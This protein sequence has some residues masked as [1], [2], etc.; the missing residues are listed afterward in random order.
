MKLGTKIILT[1]TS[2]V[3]VGLIAFGISSYVSVDKNVKHQVEDS[4]N[5][6]LKSIVA[7]FEAAKNNSM[8]KVK[9]NMQ[10]ASEHI[11]EEGSLVFSD[12]TM[13]ID[14]LNTKTQEKKT[15][16]VKEIYL[17]GK[18]LFENNE[19]ADNLSKM[20][21]AHVTIFQKV[22]GGYL[23]ISTTVK[24]NEGQRVIGTYI[25]DDS[26]V[27]QAIERG[28]TFYGR[29]LVV[30]EYFT[31]AYEPIKIDGKIEGILSLGVKEKD[32]TSLEKTILDI[33]IGDTG[34]VMAVDN[35]GIIL[36]HPNAK[37]KDDS[38]H[39][40]T[41]SL[42]ENKKGTFYYEYEGRKKIGVGTYFEPFDWY[43]LATGFTDEF[44][45]DIRKSTI[46]NTMIF[47]VIILS[48][49]GLVISIYIK[50]QMRPL[51]VLEE[52][53]K[54]ASNGDLT[55]EMKITSKDEIGNLSIEYNKF[56]AQLRETMKG[57]NNLSREVSSSNND[58]L[59][60]FDNTIKGDKSIYKNEI[61]NPLS[62]GVNQLEEQIGTVMDHIRNQTAS[63]EE[64]LAGL[65]EIAATSNTVKENAKKTLENSNKISELAYKS[66]LN[67]QN[68]NNTMKDISLNVDI[69]KDRVI[70]LS[71]LSKSIGD[72]V[73]AINGL[74]DQT[75]LLALNAA[76]EA[77]RAG[78]AGR[79]FSV[80]ADEIRKLAEKTGK[81][82]DKIEVIVTNIQNEI[83][84]VRTAT[85]K[86]DSIVEKG[87]SLSE[88][89]KSDINIIIKEIDLNNTEIN[90]IYEAAEE[91]SIGTEE[92]TKAVGTIAETS[93]EIEGLSH[94]TNEISNGLS[95]VLNNTQVTL[96]SLV[97]LAEKLR[98]DL[99][100]F[101]I[102]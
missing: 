38:Q 45:G 30:D 88:N 5:S 21:N 55:Q 65:E 74:S 75:N 40:V 13:E 19:F 71:D 3:A 97:D 22:E 61:K 2:L 47:M 35:K 7:L 44:T 102:K 9:E 10:V 25:T 6:Q 49:L 92:I 52:S 66:E 12:K 84:K 77:A 69:T 50:I 24:N 37:G 43:I 34:Y 60:I 67:V 8:S 27:V 31:C 51:G 46:I 72:I 58:L 81:E 86:V 78:E 87:S 98:K 29:A 80:V 101:K 1:V 82:T 15:F 68:L 63:T 41:K 59:K 16:Q 57:I 64:G 14:G 100:F 53:F 18:T 99:E 54:K 62:R 28:E 76:I 36:I 79:G 89:V 96:S 93:T 26:P 17:G 83:T 33:K 42:M 85:D 95:G 94:Q 39:P 32:L 70:E 91:Q 4:L 73:T 90:N 56:L 23:R 11:E 48:I 20:I